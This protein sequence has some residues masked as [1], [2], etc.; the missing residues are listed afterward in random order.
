MLIWVVLDV[1]IFLCGNGCIIIVI[2]VM[3]GCVKC[4]MFDY[5]VMCLLFV[6]VDDCKE[7]L[8][9]YIGQVVVLYV[10]EMWQFDM[11][12]CD[13]E[14]V[15]LE[16]GCIYCFCVQVVI[17]VYSGCIMGIVFF[18]FEDQIQVDFVLMWVL[19][20]K[21]GLL[22]DCYLLFGLFK[23]FYID[24]GKIYFSEYFYWIVVGLGIEIIYS[25]FCVL[26][27]CGV[28]ECFFGILYGL[29]WVM[30]GYV[31]Q[32][33]VDCFSEEF[34]K[35]CVVIQWWLD[36]GVDFGF[37]KCYQIIYEYQNSVLV[38]LIVEY[39]QCFVDGKICL[40][41][42]CE[43]VFEFSLLELDVG[44]LLLL[45]VCCIKCVVRLDGIVSIGNVVWMILGGKLVQ[46]WGLLVLVFEDQFVLGDECWGIVWQDECIGCLEMFGIVVFVFIVVVSIVVGEECCVQKV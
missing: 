40:E 18:E 27:I 45:F 24:N 19:M 26:Y 36:M 4:M 44:E 46:Y 7:F 1:M 12:C 5:L 14:V 16:I 23:W 35:L 2:V 21:F 17:D 25:L 15:D 20:W 11:I 41:Y 33:V 30:V 6:N 43:I 22:V 13:V 9:F 31:G 8:C 10:N 34:K 32:N 39:Y 28:V 42:F 3:V 38:W 37:G 29:E